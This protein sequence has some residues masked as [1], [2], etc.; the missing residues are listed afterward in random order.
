MIVEERAIDFS[1]DDVATGA[2]AAATVTYAAAGQGIRH[3]ISGVAWS[4]SAAPAGSPALTIMDGAN[5]VFVLN[6][7]AARAATVYFDPPKRGSVNTGLSVIL[8]SGGG[9][10]V[11]RVNVLA[12]WVEH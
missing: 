2:G 8:D 4:F 9:A 1:P 7:D 10:V 3:C 6:I 5:V 12:H 11:G